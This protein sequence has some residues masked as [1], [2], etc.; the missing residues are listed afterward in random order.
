MNN[1]EANPPTAISHSLNNVHQTVAAVASVTSDSNMWKVMELPRT[2]GAGVAS[3]SGSAATTAYERESSL[4]K[5]SFVSNSIEYPSNA[6]A[7]S[8]VYKHDL[9]KSPTSFNETARENVGFVFDESHPTD[10]TIE[11]L[12]QYLS[13]E[14]PFHNESHSESDDYLPLNHLQLKQRRCSSSIDIRTTNIDNEID[15]MHS[16]QSNHRRHYD[17]PIFSIDNI[18]TN[19]PKNRNNRRANRPA[20]DVDNLNGGDGLRSRA[21]SQ[22]STRL[23][24]TNSAATATI[25]MAMA[26][27]ST[28]TTPTAVTTATLK[29]AHSNY[30]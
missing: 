14:L 15:Q 11:D 19:I 7:S 16:L 12:R 27:M 13:T 29:R 10:D 1:V 8:I 18:N 21:T 20:S 30:S 2:N 26:T 24:V 6:N 9:L 23:P 25:T 17:N 4:T 5:S 28:A 3:T 22:R